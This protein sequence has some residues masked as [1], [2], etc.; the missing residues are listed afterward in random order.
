VLW[1]ENKRSFDAKIDLVTGRGMAGFA[2]WRLG[3]ED[4]TIWNTI[5]TLPTAVPS[6][7]TPP[8]FPTDGTPF[9][10]AT[11]TPTFTPTPIPTPVA[12]DP[13]APVPTTEEL[14]FFPET[15][16]TLHG[17]FLSYWKQHGGLPVYGFPITEEFIETSPT[18]GKPYT[19]QYFERNRFEYHPENAP[20][21]DVQLGL[22][23]VQLTETRT[24]APATD[25]EPGA[26]TVYFPQV[27]HTLSGAFLGYWQ[28]LGA[29]RQFGYPI[30][31]PVLE[32]NTQD[33]KTYSVQYFERAR[34]ELHP[35]NAGTQYAVLLGL[36]GLNVSPCR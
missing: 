19:V 28:A 31:E 11:D 18:D 21:N 13:V 10:T 12:C 6:T 7:Y 17:A 22:L 27:G 20:P 16:H 3:Q 14:I 15:Q 25:L 34:F 5:A 35:E 1:Y 30:S 4:P 32:Q 36:L 29:L 23:G 24:F 33:G 8:S 9:P 26:D 2:L